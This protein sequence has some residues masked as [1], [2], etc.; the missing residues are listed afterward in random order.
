MTN[1]LKLSVQEKSSRVMW[2]KYIPRLRFLART[3]NLTVRATKCNHRLHLISFFISFAVLPDV[4]PSWLTGWI[5]F[6]GLQISQELRS[7]KMTLFYCSNGQQTELFNVRAT[8]LEI[9]QNPMIGEIETK[10]KNSG[11]LWFGWSSTIL[12][13]L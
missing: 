10:F 2:P 5:T 6:I 3:A 12:H 11:I 7:R 9:N 4:N 1:M 13:I 8:F